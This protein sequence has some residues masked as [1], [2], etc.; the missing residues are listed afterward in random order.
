MAAVT[1]MAMIPF[2]IADGIHL[3]YLISVLETDGT[4]IITH[5]TGTTM[6]IMITI[7]CIIRIIIIT[8]T[9]QTDIHLQPILHGGIPAIIQNLPHVIIILPEGMYLQGTHHAIL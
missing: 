1:I 3:L 2:T 7:K 8:I 9:L 5:G 6:D 4:T